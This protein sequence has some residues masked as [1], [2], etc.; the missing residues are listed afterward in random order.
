MPEHLDLSARLGRLLQRMRH[1]DEGVRRESF[2]DA[3]YPPG[4]EPREITVYLPAH[5]QRG[6][7]V[8]LLFAL[9]GQNLPRWQLPEALWEA[10]QH[11]T[12]VAPLV[13]AVASTADRRDEYGVAGVPDYAGRGRLAAGF[14]EFLTRSLL[15]AVRARYG[16]GL[17]PARTGIF[18]AS[19]GGLCA[20]DTAWRHPEC[21]SLAGVFSGSLWWRTDDTDAGTQQ[22]S[23]IAHRR[24]RETAAKPPLRFW[25]QAG[26]EDETDDRDGNGV[27]DAIQD[28]T[29][30]VDELA[31]RGYARGRE[32]VY[33][34]TAGG[35]HDEET[36]AK[37]LPGFLRW[38]WPD[39][40]G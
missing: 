27:I 3:D 8:P 17:T 18:G 14:Q 9:D 30:L 31:A 34:E 26:T 19:L 36:W 10:G 22:A 39:R 28:T 6:D 4:L 40:G 38:A 16:A 20:F 1:G 37:E 13:V 35:R 32:V 2:G 21:F 23:R 11:R 33:R 25:F 12:A 5:Y 15:P 24:V 7:D 29:E